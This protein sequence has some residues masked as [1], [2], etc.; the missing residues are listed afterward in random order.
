MLV[1]FLV[2]CLLV[3]GCIVLGNKTVDRRFEEIRQTKILSREQQHFRRGFSGAT[4]SYATFM[5]YYTDGTHRAKTVRTD[6]HEYDVLMGKLE[7]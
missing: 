7:P 4:Y 6:H 3:L 2:C 5:V 1:G